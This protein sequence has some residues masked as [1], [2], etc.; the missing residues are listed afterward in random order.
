MLGLAAVLAVV[1]GLVVFLAL[2]EPARPPTPPVRAYPYSIN[3]SDGTAK[4]F[5]QAPKRVVSLSPDRTALLLA[6]GLGDRLVAVD[7]ASVAPAEAP[8]IPRLD[9]ISLDL[10]ALAQLKPDLVFLG[11]EHE[12][13]V[14]RLKE[15]TISYLLLWEPLNPTALEA[16]LQVFGNIFNVPSQ[17][18]ELTTDLVAQQKAVMDRVA[19]VASGPRVYYE[20]SPAPTGA[21]ETS[22]PGSLLA[23]LKARN[24]VTEGGAIFPKV[25]LLAIKARDPEVI[26][27][28]YPPEQVSLE[29]L[30][31]RPGWEEITAVKTGRVYYVDHAQVGEPTLRVKEALEALGLLLYP[32]RFSTSEASPPAGTP[33]AK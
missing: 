14:E 19:D 5:T 18:L 10:E 32:E 9:T 17:A 28:A 31:Q 24:V 11:R 2:R 25:S 23:T 21:P 8:A 13:Y 3:H 15:R 27:L 1:V 12:G 33:R 22:W 16:Q 30:K 26:L 6:L 4:V 20:V 7:T 29:T